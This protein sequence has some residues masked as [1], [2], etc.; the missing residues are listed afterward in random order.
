MLVKKTNELD[1]IEIVGDY[2]HIQIR[3]ATWV[4]DDETGETFGAKQYSRR[5]IS[6]SDD[7]SQETAEVQALVAAVH[8][9][10][11]KDAYAEFLAAQEV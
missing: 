9:Q 1:K 7:V 5:V 11:I 3:S 2:K 8:T 10:E 6:P 4:E